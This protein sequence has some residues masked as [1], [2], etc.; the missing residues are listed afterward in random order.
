MKIYTKTGDTGETSLLGGN[1]VQKNCIEIEAIGEVDELN[2]YLGILI[3]EIDDNFKK[4]R[5]K[6][7]KIQHKLFV[8][9]AELAALQ[10]K[11]VKTPKITRAN[12]TSLEKWI[13]SMQNELPKLTN[14]ILPGGSEESALAFYARAICRRAERRVVELANNYHINP[15]LQQYINRLSDLLFVLARRINRQSKVGDVK[16]QK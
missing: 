7:I 15:A 2:A 8:V 3:E 1:R 9:G 12:V 13:D 14:F 6:L 11:L 10:T 5:N 16:W 4:E